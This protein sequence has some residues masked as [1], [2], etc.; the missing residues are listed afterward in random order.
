VSGQPPAPGDREAF[1]RLLDRRYSC[2]AYRDQPVPRAVIESILESAAR[3]ASWCNAQPWVV[4]I[5]SGEPLERL[6][7]AL[8][9]HAAGSPPASP[10][11]DWPREYR[12]IYQERRRECG[13]SL[14]EAVGIAKGDR[15]GS[16]RQAAENF[17][18]F[19]APHL[20]VLTSDALLG[21]HGVMDCGAWLSNFMLAAAAEGV[22][23]VAQA[24][25]ASWPAVLRQALPIADDRVIVCG[26]SFGY[27]DDEH[28]AN[29]FRTS[30]AP[31]T[32]T[33]VWNG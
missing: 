18:L 8:A 28:P 33:T 22:A 16:A 11:L 27:A 25:L 15:E 23:T 17:R 20:G 29:R 5:V 13:W 3:T 9:A 1:R 21:T 31:L 30:R 2:R 19:G 4:H 6:R 32:E 12:G 26:V 24:A 7:E 14:Y 10:E